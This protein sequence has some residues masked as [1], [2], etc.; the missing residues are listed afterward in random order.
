MVFRDLENSLHF[1]TNGSIMAISLD[2]SA[3]TNDTHPN[4]VRTKFYYNAQ[5]VE[6]INLV[7]TAGEAEPEAATN[8]TMQQ[9]GPRSIPPGRL[10]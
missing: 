1:N 9:S 8:D 2:L 7:K 6:E 10:S 5:T 4:K 3:R